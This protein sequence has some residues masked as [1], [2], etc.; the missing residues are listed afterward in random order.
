VRDAVGSGGAT[1]EL[2]GDCAFEVEGRESGR[3]GTTREK[4]SGEGDV[5]PL[6]EAADGLW[7]PAADE[8]GVAEARWEGEPVPD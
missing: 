8:R 2:R 3:D 5:I 1:T 4:P 7:D 6:A